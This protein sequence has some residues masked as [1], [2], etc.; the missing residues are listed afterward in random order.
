MASNYHWYNNSSVLAAMSE[1]KVS[2]LSTGSSHS[3]DSGCVYIQTGSCFSAFSP[4]A[5]ALNKRSIDIHSSYTTS[6]W[7]STLT[8]RWQFPLKRRSVMMPLLSLRRVTREQQQS[9]RLR[10]SWDSCGFPS[11]TSCGSTSAGCPPTPSWGWA[12]SLPSQPTGLP[13]GPK[14]SG[15]GVTLTSSQRSYRWVKTFFLFSK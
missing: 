12:P 1:S 15:R 14:P 8:L 3:A 10:K 5:S 6:V 7:L 4:A 2:T 13:S 11:W 9:C